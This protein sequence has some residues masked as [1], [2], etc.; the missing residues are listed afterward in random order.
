MESVHGGESRAVAS[1]P[2][3]LTLKRNRDLA[4]RAA[5]GWARRA[6]LALLTAVLVLALLGAF[7]Q[8]PHTSVAASPAARL[9]VSAPRHARSGL[10]YSA[11]FRVDA[12]REVKDA[13]LVLS[14]GWADGYTFNGDVPQPVGEASRN[15]RLAFELG[16]IPAGDHYTFFASLQVNPTNVGRHRQDVELDDGAK[17]LAIV[18]RHVTV[19]P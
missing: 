15:G 19:F 6:G 13:V 3:T 16:H 11:R 10:V 8:R 7:G 5:Y 4:G 1:A 17:R 14:P 18:H 9:T 2:D 12:L